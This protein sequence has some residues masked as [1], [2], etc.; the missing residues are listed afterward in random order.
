M[1][2]TLF[3]IVSLNPILVMF[4]K[5]GE[6]LQSIGLSTREYRAPDIEKEKKLFMRPHQ[7][8]VAARCKL[9]TSTQA[10]KFDR[11]LNA[12]PILHKRRE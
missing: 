7:Y 5:G 8:N 2:N 6:P 10:F 11:L 4:Q 3:D 9:G 12:R 1:H